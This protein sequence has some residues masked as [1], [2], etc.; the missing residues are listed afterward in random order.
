M[1]SNLY[2]FIK[3]ITIKRV[4]LILLLLLSVLKFYKL[5]GGLN[6]GEPDEF[7]H[8]D[9]SESF[10]DGGLPKFSGGYWF[11]ELPLYPLLGYFVS[12]VFP[13]RYLGL[14][15]VSVI[16]LVI[17]TWAIYFFVGKKISWRAGFIS[18]LIFLLS[19]MSVYYARLGLLDMTVA[20]LSILFLFLFDSALSKKSN[21]LFLL[22][23]I[24]LAGAILVKYSALI[25]LP[26]PL[27]YFSL[28]FLRSNIVG[29]RYSNL[30]SKWKELSYLKI[31]TGPFICLLAVFFL[32]VPLAFALRTLDPYQFK[33]QTLTSLGFVRD[34]WRLRGDALTILYYKWDVFWWIGY[35]IAFLFLVGLS[36][37]KDFYRVMPVTFYG[38]I[39]TL[40]VILPHTP[41]YPR[42]F[43]PLIPFVAIIAGLGGEFLLIKFSKAN[44][45]IVTVFCGIVFGIIAQQSL[46]AWKSTNHSLIEEVGLYIKNTTV[47]ERPWI[48][49]SYWPNYFGYS[50][51]SSRA[52]WLS[53]S[54]WDASAY[55]RDI[56]ASPLEILGKEGGFAVLE[57]LYSNSPIFIH[58]DSRLR[59]WEI[60]KSRYDILKTIVDVNPNFP[61]SRARENSINIYAIRP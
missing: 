56:S 48:F 58:S 27:V 54:A 11:F 34:F 42:Y 46:Y 33:L 41:F 25:Y 53:D 52:T 3:Y 14:R 22:S 6:L 38:F 24:V 15:I 13:G 28:S 49:T 59:A 1:F 57:D 45:A 23:G 12:F 40:L 30:I 21:R 10:R 43:F 60:I 20:A 16:F 32:T 55:V 4:S 18:A 2:Y 26:I 61:H 44:F 47:S 31:P 37:T 7:I 17:L 19:P 5:D 39:L 8:A 9:V 50:A 51:G 36:R 29:L 35:P